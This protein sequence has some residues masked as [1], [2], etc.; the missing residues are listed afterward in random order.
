M[1]TSRIFSIAE[2]PNLCLLGDSW[3]R[4]VSLLC[5]LISEPLLACANVLRLASSMLCCLA[6]LHVKTCTSEVCAVGI[7]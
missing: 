2:D 1:R 5:V 7:R 3:S 4:G 6:P